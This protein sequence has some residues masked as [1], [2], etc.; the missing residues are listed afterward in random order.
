MIAFERCFITESILVILADLPRF[1]GF[2]VLENASHNVNVDVSMCYTTSNADR[3]W[4]YVPGAGMFVTSVVVGAIAV[5]KP[6]R[7]MARPFLRDI[8]FYLVAVYWAFLMMWREKVY[9]VEMI[10]KKTTK[11]TPR[12]DKVYNGLTATVLLIQ[13]HQIIT[14]MSMPIAWIRKRKC[15]HW[16][17]YYDSDLTPSQSFQ[18]MRCHWLKFLRQHQ[19]A[20]IL[21]NTEPGMHRK[22]SCRQPKNDNISVSMK[23]IEHWK[24]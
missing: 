15:R 3:P 9:L 13:Q 10:C 12:M 24:R 1:C 7:A 21:S 17:L 23:N 2:Y 6:F 20:V 11:D 4:L 19:V 18:P 16:T 8:I 22:V 14:E 5:V